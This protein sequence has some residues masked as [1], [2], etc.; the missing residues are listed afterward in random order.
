[1]SGVDVNQFVVD[2]VNQGRIH[3]FEPD[4][5]LIVRAAISERY[6]EASSKSK[7]ADAFLIAVPTPFKRDADGK[8]PAPDLSFIKAASSIL[9]L[10]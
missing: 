2:T 6:L 1:M 3:I 10:S 9:R 5:E 4:L 8:I 7:P